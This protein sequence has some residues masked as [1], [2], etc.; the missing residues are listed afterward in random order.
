MNVKQV[1]NVLELYDTATSTWE[2]IPFEGVSV[3]E[4]A[5]EPVRELSFQVAG[6]DRSDP[7]WSLL[8]LGR[9]VRFTQTVDGDVYTFE[10]TL[11]TRPIRAEGPATDVFNLTCYDESYDAE[12][13]RFIDSYPKDGVHTWSAII[14]DAWTRYGPAGV[15]LSNAAGNT[16][17]ATPVSSNLETL[18]DFMETICDRT[19]WRWYVR[20]GELHFLD[21][22]VAVSGLVLDQSLLKPGLVSESSLAD[23]SNVVYVPARFRVVDFEDI[24]KTEAG[25]RRYF[26]QYAPLVR[27]FETAGGTVQVD[28]PPRVFLGG[29]EFDTVLSE[30]D[31]E[32]DTA[33]V[34]Y[35]SENRFVRLNADPA[36][37]YELKIIYTAEIS[38]IVR[39][40]HLSSMDLFGQA[41]HVIRRSPRPSR[42]EAEAIADAFLDKNALPTSA[43]TASLHTPE[44]RAGTYYRVK[45]P[46]YNINQ[47]MPVQKLTRSWSARQ[48]LQVDVELARVPLEDDHLIIELFRRLH[49]I[50]SAQSTRV[51]RVERYADFAD[52]WVWGEEIETFW[53]SI[54]YLADAHELH[55]GVRYFAEGRQVYPG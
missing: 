46:D 10:G 47:L 25:V 11:M 4:H 39:R 32:A 16:A 53:S 42:P 5:R 49:R 1:S 15:D 34:V 36:G 19:G 17:D 54:R 50:E 38:V 44:V 21:P 52:I 30:D 43:I 24:Q 28:N 51:E 26:T 6:L 31:F 35:N 3:T 48:G 8:T 9:R 13:Y 55:P 18:F 2:A 29:V 37:S 7:L 33:D 41:D 12:R 14:E 27:E 45:I 40:E 23:V 22:S 20:D